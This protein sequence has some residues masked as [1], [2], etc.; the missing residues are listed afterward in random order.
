MSL[1]CNVRLRNIVIVQH[2]ANQ[3]NINHALKKDIKLL[4]IY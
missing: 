1:V 3:V 4:P 2:E